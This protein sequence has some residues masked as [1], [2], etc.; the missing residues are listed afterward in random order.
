MAR[1]KQVFTKTTTDRGDFLETLEGA[2]SNYSLKQHDIETSTHDLL[3]VTIYT[4]VVY[5]F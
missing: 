4:I 3:G 2:F 5:R 1:R